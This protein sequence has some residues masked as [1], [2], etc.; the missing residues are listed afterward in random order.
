MWRALQIRYFEISDVTV[1][2]TPSFTSNH[3]SGNWR[4]FFV[5]NQPLDLAEG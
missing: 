2:A 1:E 4:V 3:P 5:Y